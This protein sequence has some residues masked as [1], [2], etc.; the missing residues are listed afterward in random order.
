MT[1]NFRCEL[2]EENALRQ[3][4]RVGPS[5][6]T[7]S[8]LHLKSYQQKGKGGVIVIVFL[9]SPF[10]NYLEGTVLRP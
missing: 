7:K 3:I 9:Q 8:E 1:V 10:G 2:D 4:L 6:T 5:P